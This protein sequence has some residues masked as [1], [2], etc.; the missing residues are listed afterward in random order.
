[1]SEENATSD[2]EVETTDVTRNNPEGDS[3]AFIGTAPTYQEAYA[4][5][6]SMPEIFGVKTSDFTDHI[7]PLSQKTK[8]Q[9]DDGN[10]EWKQ[11][12]RLYM[13]VAGRV[14]MVQKACEINGW[15]VD[16]S[17]EANVPEGNPAG[18]LFT[19]PSY[20][21]RE[22]CNIYH[23]VDGEVVFVGSK[24]GMSMAKG[25]NN[26]MEK[27]ETSA[28][29]RSIAAWGF[30]VL[31]G[32]GIASLEE[33]QSVKGAEVGT[34]LAGKKRSKGELLTSVN[35][36]IGS[37]QKVKGN[38]ADTVEPKILGFVR[39]QFGKDTLAELQDGQLILVE[40]KLRASL[41]Q[42]AD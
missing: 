11:V 35:D 38:T 3:W 32:S 37:L 22:Y 5:L 27:L 9:K 12:W 34:K 18:F 40:R 16:F 20:V 21:Y 6:D 10:V 33:M 36:L 7:L 19:E 24:P 2:I 42:E 1:M 29:G 28:R 31:P 8:I 26:V 13:T 17:P 23:H 25:G 4:L 41:A 30:G 15:N 39:E 14:A